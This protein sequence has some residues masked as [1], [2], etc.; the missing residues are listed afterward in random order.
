[1]T[2]TLN[3]QLNIE[4]NVTIEGPGADLLTLDAQ[5]NSRHFSIYRFLN[6]YYIQHNFGGD[7]LVTIQGLTLANGSSSYGGAIYTKEDLIL[8]DVIIRDST[9]SVDGGA[10]ANTDGSGELL[11]IRNSK[12][13]STK[14]DLGERSSSSMNTQ[15]WRPV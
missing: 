11:I 14:P 2:L 13:I 15:G 9:A 5:D 12:L 1:M 4:S 3:S 8:D 6:D 10:I 7:V